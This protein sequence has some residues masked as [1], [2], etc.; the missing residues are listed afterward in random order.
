MISFRRQVGRIIVST[1]DKML[2]GIS[3]RCM[4]SEFKSLRGQLC[5]SSLRD[6][7]INDLKRS[8]RRRVERRVGPYRYNI[9]K[10]GM[11]ERVVDIKNDIAIVKSS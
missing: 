11:A 10:P 4:Q 3:Y 7:S 2:S 6:L 8:D 9:F 1:W 5:I